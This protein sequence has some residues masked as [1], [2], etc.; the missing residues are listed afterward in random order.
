MGEFESILDLV[1]H[2]SREIENAKEQHD[3]IMSENTLPLVFLHC[4]Y[5]SLFRRDCQSWRRSTSSIQNTRDGIPRLTEP[6]LH[7]A[8]C[9]N[10]LNALRV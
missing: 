9:R 3:Q 10:G 1:R 2:M 4:N 8:N 7:S 6:S 5:N